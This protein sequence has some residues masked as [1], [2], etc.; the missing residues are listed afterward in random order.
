[1]LLEATAL[2]KSFGENLLFSDVTFKIEDNDKI[3]LVGQNGSGK[4]TLFKLLCREEEP[5]GGQVITKRG[6]T[7]G[8][9]KQHACENS[10]LSTYS[11][12][13]SVFG[14]LQKI[15]DQLE[16]V[17]LRLYPSNASASWPHIYEGKRS[18]VAASCQQS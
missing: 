12:A 18:A 6:L 5:D 15:E 14:E 3:G 4:T 7:I 11:E 9:L 17:N 8:Q 2:S 10:G 1:M 16:E 13:L